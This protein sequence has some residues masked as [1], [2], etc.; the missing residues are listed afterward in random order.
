ME[1]RTSH[2]FGKDVYLLG[3]DKYNEVVWLES[4]KWDCGWYWGFGYIETYTNQNN[5][6]M[7]KD[8][9]CHTH[10][11]SIHENDS[12]PFIETTFSKD[13]YKELKTLF[14]RFY[15][16]TKKAENLHSKR[17]NKNEYYHR[18]WKAIND[19]QIPAIT[20]QIINIIKP[21]K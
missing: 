13:E 14:V 17:Y 19:F 3:K 16:L 2:A 1:K 8:I 7:A 5:P 21:E 4:P 11:D 6:S 18:I 12:N 15:K 10:W 9:T 20:K